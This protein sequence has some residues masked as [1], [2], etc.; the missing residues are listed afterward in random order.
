M[1]VKRDE[2]D[3]VLRIHG[4]R[5][6]DDD[7]GTHKTVEEDS[8][9]SSSMGRTPSI[10]LV[11]CH[12]ISRTVKRTSKANINSVFFPPTALANRPPPDSYNL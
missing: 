1:I 12:T 4:G 2:D 8:G 11:Q 9:E 5:H 3:I 10:N 7:D 6:K